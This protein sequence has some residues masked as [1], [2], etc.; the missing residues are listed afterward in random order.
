MHEC[1]ETN[2]RVAKVLNA[3]RHEYQYLFCRGSGHGVG[4]GKAQTSN[5]YC[6]DRD[7]HLVWT[8]E[9]PF[10][11]DTYSNN[12]IDKGTTLLQCASWDGF[13]CEL[14]SSTGR[15]IHKAFTK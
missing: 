12:V 10:P 9:L 14:D 1:V 6:L 11:T 7:L 2:H 13:T 15:I 8:A 3:T 4:K 5:V